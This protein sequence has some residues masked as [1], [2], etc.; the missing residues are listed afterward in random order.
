VPL[1]YDAAIEGVPSMVGSCSAAHSNGSPAY[2]TLEVWS[3]AY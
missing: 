3:I 2:L 1:K